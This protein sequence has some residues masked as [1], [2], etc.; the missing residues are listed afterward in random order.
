ME[1]SKISGLEFKLLTNNSSKDLL[2][3]IEKIDNDEFTHPWKISDLESL[4]SRNNN[5]FFC[6]LLEN[7]IINYLILTVIKPEAEIIRIASDKDYKRLGIAQSQ[8]E[9]LFNYCRNNGLEKIF[10]EVASR[11]SSAIS[12][13]KKNG[14]T[15]TGLRRNYYG[16][17]DALLM[18]KNLCLNSIKSII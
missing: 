9:N 4:I 11:N 6:A 13:Y 5:I 14:F 7:K 17:D 2:K 8:F 1:K 10:L 15:Q 12:L 16:D 18:E 3:Q